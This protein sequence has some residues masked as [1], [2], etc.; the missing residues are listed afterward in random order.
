MEIKGKF[1]FKKGD[2][3]L[4]E[5]TPYWVVDSAKLVNTEEDGTVVWHET[6]ALSHKSPEGPSEIN[7]VFNVEDLSPFPE[8]KITAYYEGEEVSAEIGET[9]L[10]DTV[11]NGKK[12]ETALIM[13]PIG[14]VSIRD[15]DL[16]NTPIKTFK[17]RFP[18][19]KSVWNGAEWEANPLLNER[20]LAYLPSYIV[21][22]TIDSLGIKPDQDEI[23][24]IKNGVLSDM[25]R[26][27]G[28]WT[29]YEQEIFLQ[30]KEVQRL[31][32]EGDGVS[33]Y[34]KPSKKE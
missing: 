26:F 7:G 34:Y 27:L 6:Y 2:R 32:K 16:N 9:F 33:I 1:K 31:E 29:E 25:L 12:V 28:L 24:A 13:T 15:L 17:D 10:V 23:S 18:Y 19:A 14:P 11:E 22:K 5:N 21:Q 4:Y 8:G 20:R 3:V 30:M